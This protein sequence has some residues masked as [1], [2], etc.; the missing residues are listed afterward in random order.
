[1]TTSNPHASAI[2]ALPAAKVPRLMKAAHRLASHPTITVDEAADILN[3]A[4]T[5][6]GLRNQLDIE[7][8]A[9]GNNPR[10]PFAGT[11]GAPTNKQAAFEGEVVR[12]LKLIYARGN[13]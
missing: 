6:I 5:S 9:P 12:N 4:A 13:K 1:M 10:V 11:G 2:L 7:M 8:A 3:A